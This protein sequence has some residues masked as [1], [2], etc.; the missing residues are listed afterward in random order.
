MFT[1]AGQQWS[2]PLIPAMGRQRQAD[3]CEVQ[4]SL[5]HRA[6]SRTARDT[7]KPCLEIPKKKTGKARQGKARQGK[8]IKLGMRALI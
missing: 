7:Q 2:T 5:V 4:A 6:C 3:L 8:A 1:V